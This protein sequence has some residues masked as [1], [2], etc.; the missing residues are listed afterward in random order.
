MRSVAPASTSDV[1]L[2]TRPWPGPAARII[3]AVAGLAASF[4]LA[5]PFARTAFA[6]PTTTFGSTWAVTYEF[7]G[8]LF[9]SAWI[10]HV[11]H[12]RRCVSAPF[13]TAL[14]AIVGGILGALA[15]Y[16]GD[17]TSTKL[18][19]SGSGAMLVH[20]GLAGAAIC[21]ASMFICDPKS[22]SIGRAIIGAILV[23]I[24]ATMAYVI[25][26]PLMLLILTGFGIHA[27]GA[28]PVWATLSSYLFLDCVPF[29]SLAYWSP[30]GDMLF[31]GPYLFLW[32]EFRSTGPTIVE[33]P[34]QNNRSDCHN[35]G[36][37]IGTVAIRRTSSSATAEQLGST[38]AR[39]NGEPLTN[40]PLR[41]GD[42][43]TIGDTNGI[44]CENHWLSEYR[45]DSPY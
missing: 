32:S 28:V 27:R 39:L 29:G 10:T 5:V 41:D 26:V 44:F 34:L 2:P 9:V 45:P 36:I 6:S 24:T 18:N 33:I 12:R 25:V 43:L 4:V 35:A 16:V 15:D 42:R 21:L 31:R 14:S 37:R 20:Y 11:I 38:Q 40:S 30:Y 13:K 1:F 8:G 3:G 19:E 7:S 23:C 22:A 17:L